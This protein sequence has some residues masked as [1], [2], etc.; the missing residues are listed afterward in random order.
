MSEE[1]YYEEGGFD[2]EFVPEGGPFEG[3]LVTR[4][5]EV[6][7]YVANI[8][9]LS[10]RSRN[11]YA[12]EGAE[13]SGLDE[14][15]LR[16]ALIGVCA[17]R[18]EEVAAA[19]EAEQVEPGP[20][21]ELPEVSPEEIDERVGRPGVLD[22]LVEAAAAC[23]KVIAERKP[24]GLISLGALSAQLEKL[25]S[26]KPLGA[27]VILTSPAGRGKNYLCDAVARLLPEEYY[28]PFESASAKALYYVA[29]EDTEF[30]R[31]RWL[32]PNE[33]EGADLLVEILRPLL[34]G[35]S[36]RH[37]TVNKDA[38]GRNV[39]Q[40]FTVEG[41]VSVTIPTIRN[42]LDNQ[43]Q[44]RMLIADLKDYEGRVAAH[45]RAVSEQLSPGYVAAE[46]D[47]DIRAWR[48]ALR[49]LTS[50]RKVVIPVEDE[51]FHFASDE[52]SH[53]ARLWTNML[54]LMAT[55]AWLEQRNR[56]MIELPGGGQA[57]V[58][59][60]EDYEAAYQIFEATCE[61]SVLN[62]SETHKKILD[63]M[64]QLQKEPVDGSDWL[65]WTGLSQRKIAQAA[66]VSQSTVSENKTF[67]V[68]SAKL[69][70]PAGQ[71]GLA[72]VKDAEP[73]WWNTGDA[74]LGF[75]KPDEVRSWWGGHDPTPSGPEGTDRADHEPEPSP[76]A[77][78]EA[79]KDD[80]RDADQ[81]RG[82]DDHGEKRGAGQG[83]RRAEAGDRKVADRENGL[84]KANDPSDEEV[85]GVIGG[86]LSDDLSFESIA[87]SADHRAEPEGRPTPVTNRNSSDG[88]ERSGTE[89][90]NATA[91]EESQER[92]AKVE[93]ALRHYGID[94]RAEAVYYNLPRLQRDGVFDDI[95][96]VPTDREVQEAQRT[97]LAGWTLPKEVFEKGPRSWPPYLPP[98]IEDGGAIN[99]DIPLQSV[100][101]N[102]WHKN[103][104]NPEALR[105]AVAADFYV[106]FVPTI[107]EIVRAMR[108]NGVEPELPSD[109]QTAPPPEVSPSTGP[110]EEPISELERA[111]RSAQ[112]APRPVWPGNDGSPNKLQQWI[113]AKGG[114]YVYDSWRP[115]FRR[116][117]IREVISELLTK[118][119]LETKPPEKEVRKVLAKMVRE[120]DEAEDRHHE[121][122]WRGCR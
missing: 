57:V 112:R 54:S 85:I 98:P 52:V 104:R 95:G 5:P 43:L 65:S 9:L 88:E 70:R 41:P 79:E 33:A 71:G 2:F 119:Y 58:A 7:P 13:Y 1:K 19:Q 92:L 56:E 116:P 10:S 34:S 96:F 69:V 21:E 74:L 64:Y 36:A 4:F 53:G 108:M 93:E 113:Q 63:A 11:A 29:E 66:G 68:K 106:S 18:N 78:V 107:E 50:V 20:E 3:R 114:K 62:L 81:E 30:L 82:T 24:L 84:P 22:R 102:A 51:R 117:A 109:G 48:Q 49:S 91:G 42:K 59:S 111:L 103:E 80:R 101:K 77:P 76:N 31:Y 100:W 60:A 99:C 37:V 90:V 27:N 83:D 45:S 97:V 86:S 26:G 17:L 75:P 105:D 46:H 67:L 89:D 61:R 14:P 39:G 87:N 47:D 55:H 28:F 32:Y 120:K 122:V 15:G 38:S 115:A 25:P 118:G 94:H 40:E 23:S 35:G 73:S 72:L 44:S 6:P 12:R 110:S 121:R 8:S 16:G